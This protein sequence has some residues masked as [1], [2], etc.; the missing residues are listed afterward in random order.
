M[1][2]NNCRY[3]Y[4]KFKQKEGN[5][6]KQLGVKK[7]NKYTVYKMLALRFVHG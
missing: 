6:K 2:L 1:T 3:L 4:Y 5:E 7:N